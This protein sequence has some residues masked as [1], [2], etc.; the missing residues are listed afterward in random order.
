MNV[1]V[2]SQAQ[3]DDLLCELYGLLVHLI[4]IFSFLVTYN[5]LCT[6]QH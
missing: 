1:K 6:C 5:V 3:A 4:F 2:L